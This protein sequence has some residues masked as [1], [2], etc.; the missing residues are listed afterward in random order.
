MTLDVLERLLLRAILAAGL[1]PASNTT[2]RWETISQCRA[3]MQ[4]LFWSRTVCV[5]PWGIATHCA[6]G[7]I[8]ARS[9]C[10]EGIA[11]MYN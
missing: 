1:Y 10:I 11:A 8:A 9:N 2:Q 5:F 6:V 4:S 7:R 3:T